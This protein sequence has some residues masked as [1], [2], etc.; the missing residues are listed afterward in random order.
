MNTLSLSSR[1]GLLKPSPTLGITAKANAMKAEG[2][3]VIGFGAGEP[4][5][6]TPEPIVRAAI[7]ALEKGFTKYTPSA[8]IKELREAIAAKLLR[9]NGLSYTPDQIVTS[10]G[11]KHSVYNTMQVLLDAGDEVILIAPYWMTYADQIRLAGG[12]PVVIHTTGDANFVP[13]YDQ[14]KAA[15]TPRTKAIVVNSPS[16]PSG[17]VLPRQTLKEIATLALRHGL[18]IVADEIYERLVYGGATAP[19]IGSLGND[20]F[21]QTITIN[22]CSKTYSMT[23]WRIGYAAAPLPVAKAMSNLQDQVTSGPTTFAQKGAIEAY[24][25]PNEAVEGMRAEFESRRDLIVGLLRQIPGIKVPEP[26]GAFY[27]FPDVSAYL[28]NDLATDDDLASYL[29]TEAKVAVVPGSVFEGNG[30]IRLSYATS[31]KDIERGV[32]RI[33]EAL[34]RRTA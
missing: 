30:H 15:V 22:G 2:I 11:A 19:S 26:Q 9:E 34:G 21:E 25:L 4:D 24:N 33:A 18:W 5:F 17:A 27:V 31:R 29:L 13:T 32:A 12:V 8:G 1:A 14:L 10:C 6:P 7:D 20:V 16:N 23:G 3:D 28:G